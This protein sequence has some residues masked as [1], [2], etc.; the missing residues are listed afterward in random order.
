MSFSNLR[1]LV[2][3]PLLPPSPGGGGIYTQLLVNG[4]LNKGHVDYAAVLTEKFPSLPE[5]ELL[6]E[7]K[8]E[9]LR[10]FPFRAGVLG[11][12]ASRYFFY[13]LQNIYFLAIPWIAYRL[14]ISHI[15]IHSSF[16][17]HPN[18]MWLAVR[19]MRLFLPSITLISDVRDPKLPNARFGEIRPYHFVICCS[20]NVHVHLAKSDFLKDKLVT[21]PIV[22]DIQ[23]PSPSEI[24]ACKKKYGLD[25]IPYL[26]NGSGISREK[27]IEK[28]LEVVR[29]LRENNENICLVVAGRKR[30]WSSHH[31][32][33]AKSG[34][35]RY[36]GVIP[37]RD[38][39]CLS[40]GS[41]VDVNFSVVDSMPRATLEALVAGAKVLLPRGVPEFEKECADFIV[42]SDDTGEITNQLEAI[43]SGQQFP[44]YNITPHAPDSVFAQYEQLFLRK[45]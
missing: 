4:L 10:Y 3:T 35:L 15:L 8:L 14:K 7:N 45:V 5:R 40:A 25:A 12:A 9:I 38:V 39:F 17:N 6:K 24:L 16:H 18:L 32:H 34:L 22:I 42:V 44:S 41:E 19:M 31:E 20:E 29:K 33:A 28:A 21:I 43:I 2:V 1:I 30:D 27:G 23:K 11:R 37:H 36:V 13:L 26:F